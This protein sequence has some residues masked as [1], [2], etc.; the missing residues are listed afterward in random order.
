MEAE[1]EG[2]MQGRRR[3]SK[4]SKGARGRGSEK[5]KARVIHAIKR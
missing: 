2:G 3:E 1:V 5:H 4:G